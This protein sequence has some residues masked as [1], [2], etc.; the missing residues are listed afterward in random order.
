MCKCIKMHQHLQWCMLQNHSEHVRPKPT[1]L[2]LIQH[3]LCLSK[4]G[5]WNVFMTAMCCPCSCRVCWTGTYWP[6][7][8]TH[9]ALPGDFGTWVT[10][11]ARFSGGLHWL[12]R[13]IGCR[14]G[15]PDDGRWASLYTESTSSSFHAVLF[16]VSTRGKYVYHWAKTDS[17]TPGI[18]CQSQNKLLSA[19]DH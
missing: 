2:S 5:A 15:C 18:S 10:P 19:Y 8:V 6:D 17:L 3:C 14:D 16:Y 12:L 1:C 11:H 4:V 9:W 13:M 7:R